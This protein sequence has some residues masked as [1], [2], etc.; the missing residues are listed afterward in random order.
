MRNEKFDIMIAICQER[1]TKAIP[2]PNKDQ[3]TI[4]G[5]CTHQSLAFSF[6]GFV[7]FFYARK[8]IKGTRRK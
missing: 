4:K 3:Q 1:Y 6:F 7:S 2:C 8:R 5:F